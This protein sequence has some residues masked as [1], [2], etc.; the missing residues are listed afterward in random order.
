MTVI[1]LLDKNIMPWRKMGMGV[2]KYELAN[3]GKMV[4]EFKKLPLVDGA[5]TAIRTPEGE[6][7]IAQQAQFGVAGVQLKIFKDGAKKETAKMQMNGLP[8]LELA[9]GVRYG[10]GNRHGA[11]CWQAADGTLLL[12]FHKDKGFSGGSGYIEIAPDARRLPEFW[13]LV[14]LGWYLTA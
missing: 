10:W 2:T 7:R 5:Y 14:A 8:V 13:L 6:W 9:N 4:A 1:N 11:Q 12:T 3:E